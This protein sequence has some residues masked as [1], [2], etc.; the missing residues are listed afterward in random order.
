MLRPDGQPA[1]DLRED[2]G[3]ISPA[4]GAWCSRPARRW[5]RASARSEAGPYARR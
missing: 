1:A 2:L 4:P 5:E 3:G